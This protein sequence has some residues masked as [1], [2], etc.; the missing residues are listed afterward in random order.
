[1][2]RKLISILLCFLLL[3][4]VFPLSVAVSAASDGVYTIDTITAQTGDDIVVNINVADNPGT[5]AMTISITYDSSVLTYKRYARGILKDY[6]VADHPD[7]NLIRFVTCDA[8]DVTD[9]GLIISLQFTVKGDAV[10]DFYPISIQYSLGDFCD[11]SLKKLSPTIAPGGV[12]VSYNGTNCTHKTYGSWKTVIAAQCS[13]PGIRQRNCTLCGRTENGD[14]PQ[15]K[16]EYQNFY[17]VD[18]PATASQSGTM[19]RHCKNCSAVT[20]IKNFSLDDA[21]EHNINNTPDG[22]VPPNDFTGP[23]PSDG[24]DTAD[25]PDDHS[26]DNTDSEEETANAEDLVNKKKDTVKKRGSALGG[27]IYRLFFKDDGGLLGRVLEIFSDPVFLLI[28]I[29]LIFII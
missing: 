23:L 28:C 19:S 8:K 22:V 7:R 16:H 26:S 5:A 4:G 14:I 25:P 9:D 13:S 6:T 20:D 21:G 27:L 2:K 24:S 10:A 15:L 3:L 17:T 12:N 29:P 11:W 1:M 18:E